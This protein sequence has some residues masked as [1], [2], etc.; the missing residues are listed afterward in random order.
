MK[1]IND[2]INGVKFTFVCETLNNGFSLL[3]S[4]RLLQ[5]D[6]EIGN[7]NIALT[8]KP[9]VEN[10]RLVIQCL[11]YDVV[12]SAE[13]AAKPAF[14]ADRGYKRMT[15]SRVFE[16]IQYLQHN[17]QYTVYNDLFKKYNV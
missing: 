9:A 12:K 14:L 5:N 8:N 6:V 2:E 15:N 3:Q 7:Y 16:F 1:I 17:E 10:Y 4:A 11:I 13:K